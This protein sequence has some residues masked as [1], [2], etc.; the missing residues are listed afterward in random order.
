[1]KVELIRFYYSPHDE[2]DQRYHIDNKRALKQL[3]QLK[4]RGTE[5]EI[6]DVNEIE[7][8]FPHYHRATVGPSVALR[9]VFGTKGALEEDFGRSVPALVCYESKDDLY[10]AEVFPRMDRRLERMLG[11]NEVLDNLLTYGNTVAPAIEAPIPDEVELEPP[12]EVV[13]IE[14]PE[15]APEAVPAAE[16]FVAATPTPE[17][18]AVEEEVIVPAEPRFAQ[19]PPPPTAEPQRNGCLGAVIEW[20]VLLFLGTVLATAVTLGILYAFNGTLDFSRVRGVREAQSA[21]GQLQGKQAELEANA[22]A[23]QLEADR[24]SQTLATLE[25]K[26]NTLEDYTGTIRNDLEVAKRDI[27]TTSKDVETLRSDVKAVAT[28]SA[29]FDTFLTRLRDVL[30]EIQGTPVPTATPTPTNTRT[31]T[32][33]PTRTSTPTPT[34]TRTPTRV[35]PT[36]TPRRTPTRKPS[37]TPTTGRTPTA[38]PT[39]TPTTGRTPTATPTTGPTPTP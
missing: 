37:A 24:L 35:P 3:E 27:E 20:L 6:L 21:I 7:D 10:P 18:P 8:L 28:E 1:M 34:A 31:P 12:A 13:T 16:R 19:P 14:E 9:P 15:A 25:E 17:A 11:I 30:I 2:P 36:S 38:P 26:A 33:T 32:A 39:A 22:K 23:L 29:H 4:Q 5:V